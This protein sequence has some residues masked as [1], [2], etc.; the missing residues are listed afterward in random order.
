MLP[1]TGTWAPLVRA[2]AEV[3]PALRALTAE[4]QAFSAAASAAANNDCDGL[5]AAVSGVGIADECEVI[6][7][8]FC[9]WTCMNVCLLL[10]RAFPFTP[11]EDPLLEA[12]E[13]AASTTRLASQ[14]GL[15]TRLT[16]A[17][18]A[19]DAKEFESIVVELKLKR[20]CVQLCHWVCAL[21]CHVFCHCV[22]PPLTEAFFTHIGGLAYADPTVVASQANGNGLTVADNRAFFNTLRL[23]GDLS[24][25][26]GAPLVE[27]RFEIAP[28]SPHG[29]TR[30]CPT[31]RYRRC[32]P[33]SPPR[34][35]CLSPQPRS[36]RRR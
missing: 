23:N 32:P 21:R 28:T 19:R 3:G 5:R 34:R 26:D 10:C 6:C 22:C 25:V 4:P 13:F 7:Q 12:F 36:P 20:S 17:I 29:G 1:R 9:T 2:L 18:G 35:G 24:V 11:I 16:T 15:V 8:W 14:P 31:P 30:R 33:R 27:Y